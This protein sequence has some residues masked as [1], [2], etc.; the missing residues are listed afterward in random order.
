MVNRHWT[1]FKN[2]SST[3]LVNAKHVRKIKIVLVSSISR[4]GIFMPKIGEC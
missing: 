3:E 4:L 2:E 1:I